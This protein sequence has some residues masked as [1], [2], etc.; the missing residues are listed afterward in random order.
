VL[1]TLKTISAVIFITCLIWL[2]AEAESL[3]TIES[4]AE[5]VFSSDAG[6]NRT[7]D[8]VDA[9]DTT[10]QIARVRIL[11]EIEGSASAIDAVERILRKPVNLSP[12]MESVPREPGDRVV[13]LRD[14][15]RNHPDIRSHGITIKKVDP[16][17]VRVFI[18]EIETRAI[19]VLASIPLSDLDGAVE[20][21][22]ATVKLHLPT[23]QAKLLTENSYATARIEPAVL[24]SLARGLRQTLP[25]VPLALP[26]ELASSTHAWLET[27][28][29]DV[30]LTLRTQTRSIKIPSVPVHLRLA[31]GEFGK[32]EIEI[33][34]QDRFLTDVT[35]TG[36]NDK[37]QAV[38]DKTVSVLATISLSFEELERGIAS[39]EATFA[40]LPEGLKAETANKTVRVTIKRR[41]QEKKAQ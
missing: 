12:G 23:S 38:E 2:F 32:W 31:P 21:R 6:S 19:K 17:D 28:T 26:N 14:A 35:I 34:E 1:G 37:V 36:P 25:G 7:I 18:D 5:I 8:L 13:N 30:S 3:R 9:G 29:A 39:K 27:R 24:E 16:Q 20:I 11:V 4:P 22:P 15:L 33:P 41:V 10:Q 40:D